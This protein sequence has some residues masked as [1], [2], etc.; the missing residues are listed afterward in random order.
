MKNFFKFIS[1]HKSQRVNHDVSKS[2]QRYRFQ[3][4]WDIERHMYTLHQKLKQS[5]KTKNATMI[6]SILKQIE[7]Y[8]NSHN[9]LVYGSLHVHNLYH[10]LCFAIEMQNHEGDIAID[11][12]KRLVYDGA[13][14]KI[15]ELNYHITPIELEMSRVNKI[16]DFFSEDETM[17]QALKEMLSKFLFETNRWIKHMN[18]VFDVRDSISN[19]K[20]KRIN[21]YAISHLLDGVDDAI[22][23]LKS[24]KKVAELYAVIDECY[25]MA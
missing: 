23:S 10:A 5:I 9:Y 4:T 15:D 6:T 20:S 13:K 22:E 25:K 14:L 17:L 1:K 8:K 16:I 24:P 2:V 3:M 18:K 12:I 19:T 7:E 11:I 21:T